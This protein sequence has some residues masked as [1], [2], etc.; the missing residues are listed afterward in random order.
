MMMTAAESDIGRHMKTPRVDEEEEFLSHL[1]TEH[2]SVFHKKNLISVTINQQRIKII[3][4]GVYVPAVK[5]TRAVFSFST[6]WPQHA[7]AHASLAF[8]LSLFY[9]TYLDLNSTIT[10]CADFTGAN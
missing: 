9:N 2:K 4:M 3:H 1:S 10:R 6:R 8:V 7:A 5:I